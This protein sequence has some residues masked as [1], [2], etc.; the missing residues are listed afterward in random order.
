VR[1]GVIYSVRQ[2]LEP[3]SAAR[4][5]CRTIVEFMAR[6]VALNGEAV[7]PS[8]RRATCASHPWAVLRIVAIPRIVIASYPDW[9]RMGHGLPV[10]FQNQAIRRS[11]EKQWKNE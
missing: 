3:G 4:A 11:K 5:E 7:L 1:E 8:T 2:N 10:P 9:Q 6:A